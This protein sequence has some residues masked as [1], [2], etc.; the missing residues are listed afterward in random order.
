MSVDDL[1]KYNTRVLC[2]DDV[3]AWRALRREGVEKF[4]TAF[5][6]NLEELAQVSVEQDQKRLAQGNSYGVFVGER[7]VGIAGIT[8]FSVYRLAHRAECGPYYVTPEYHGRGAGRV[9]MD[10]LVGEA[11]A[12]GV[13]SFE[14][15]VTADN[16]RAHAFYRKYGFYDIARVPDAARL[17]ERMEDDFLMRLDL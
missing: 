5:L 15:W 11:R 10:H 3:N 2:E 9:L 7:L 16:I 6:P 1:V 8:W 4:P 17:G 12:R 13:T 14:L